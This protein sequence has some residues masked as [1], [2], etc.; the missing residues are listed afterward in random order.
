M[1][2]NRFSRHHSV[3]VAFVLVL[4]IGPISP[5]ARAQTFTGQPKLTEL[6][7]AGFQGLVYPVTTRPGEIR[8]NI[9]NQSRGAVR[10]QFSDQRGQLVYDK[11]ESIA[12]YRQ[13]FDLSL[14]PAGVYT[15]ILS[16]DGATHTQTFRIEPPTAGRLV[17]I[18]EELSLESSKS[19]KL[20]VFH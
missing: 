12:R 1:K 11:F 13:Y 14:M 20:I 18:N 19:E 15:I 7:G 5:A 17:L 8:I 10:V 2:I 6:P 4:S 16:K 3:R 9:N